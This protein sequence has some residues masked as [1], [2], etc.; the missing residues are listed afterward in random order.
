MDP[1]SLVFDIAG[2][3]GLATTT[4]RFATSY[5]SGVKNGKES[6]A[7]L[8]AEL[9]ALRI[10]LASLDAFLRSASAKDL[11]F[12]PTS[13][14]RSCTTACEN[15]LK[16]LCKKLGQVGESKTSRF[17]WPISEK[18]HQ[19]TMQDL[20]NFSRWMQFALSIDGCSLLSRTSD[21]VLK[22]LKG[23]FEHFKMLQSLE[24]TTSQLKDAV[25]YQNRVL[26]D[27]SSAKLRERILSWLS[28]IIHDQKHYSVRQPRVAGTGS[29]FLEEP[30]FLK[31][32]DGTSSSN[33][34]WCHGL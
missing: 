10:N 6:I 2:L 22:V 28:E 34:L 26:Q 29:W 9:E 24:N 14:L 11:T 17:L 5:M 25:G 1:F 13:V 19:K 16:A 21:D 7:T 32:R 31:W 12:Q 33:V 20:R 4:I 30:E 3:V 27:K 8:I 23:Q 15:S 18:D